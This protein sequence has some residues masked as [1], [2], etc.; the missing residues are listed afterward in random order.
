MVRWMISLAILAIA[1]LWTPAATQQERT[2]KEDTT[3]Q[4]QAPPAD[5]GAI[6]A[7][8]DSAMV[9]RQGEGVSTPGHRAEPGVAQPPDT[10]HALTTRQGIETERQGGEAGEY[11]PQ[12]EEPKGEEYGAKPGGAG[13][14][15]SLTARLVD[16][17]KKA[18]KREATVEASASGI[19]I[20][21]P[22]ST[23]EKAVPGQG[24]F[25]YRL[26]GGPIIA[27][28]SDKLSFHELSPGKH[29][30]SV[31]LAGN[32]HKPLGPEKKLYVDIR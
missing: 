7:I 28:T 13:G 2:A 4:G 19:Q 24:H 20:V 15:A 8:G 30:I 16:A 9:G 27:T 23:G 25:H 6:D 22:A 14:A 3:Y 18:S 17:E 26:D 21:D 10:S 32:D 11:E 1:A 31:V 29:T 12:G 5:E